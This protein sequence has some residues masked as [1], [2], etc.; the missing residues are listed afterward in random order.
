VW[1]EL[2]VSELEFYKNMNH[3]LQAIDTRLQEI[4]EEYLVIPHT[5]PDEE[6]GRMAINAWGV[7]NAVI[8][9]IETEES[10]L[11]AK[12]RIAK[13]CSRIARA[14][15]HLSGE[16]QEIIGLVYLDDVDYTLGVKGRLLG[17][18]TVHSFKR[19]I[20]CALLRFYRSIIREKIAIRKQNEEAHRK[21]MQQELA[22]YLG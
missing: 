6:S 17:Y 8:W 13:R 18:S 1:E 3:N 11:K 2:A 4:E 19:A 12:E 9:K 10:L 14:F 16:D 7:E 20:R 15:N 21:K 5:Y 22:D